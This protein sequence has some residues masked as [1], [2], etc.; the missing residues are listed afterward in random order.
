MVPISALFNL[1]NEYEYIESSINKF[2]DGKKLIQI[3]KA[4]GFKR[5]KYITIFGGQM[6]LLILNK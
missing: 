3:S 6:G 1:K 5:V 2:P 4:I